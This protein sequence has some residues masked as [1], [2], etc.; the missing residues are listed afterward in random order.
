MVAGGFQ[1]LIEGG[2]ELK[3]GPWNT[4]RKPTVGK[5]ANRGY[6]CAQRGGR[7]GDCYRSR[8]AHTSRFL[9]CVRWRFQPH[10]R[11]SGERGL[12]LRWDRI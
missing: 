4:G 12:G 10:A 7:G 1:R 6:R 9:R 3:A 11:Q 2:F 5:S 8:A